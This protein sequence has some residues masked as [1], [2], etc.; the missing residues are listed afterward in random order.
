MSAWVPL[1]CRSQPPALAP[2]P[3][4]QLPPGV[5]ARAEEGGRDHPGK[6]V[7]QGPWLGSGSRVGRTPDGEG[8]QGPETH[9]MTV[10]GQGR[11]RLRWAGELGTRRAGAADPERRGRTGLCRLSPGGLREEEGAGQEEKGQFQGQGLRRGS[12]GQTWWKETSLWQQNHQPEGL[13]GQGSPQQ[14]EELVTLVTG[15]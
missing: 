4:S 6:V 10:R 5:R 13:P 3:A 11:E 12:S 9:Q 2:A 15:L 1:P 8:R 7:S 14:T